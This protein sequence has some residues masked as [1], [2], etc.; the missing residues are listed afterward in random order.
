[1]VGTEKHS[2][3]RRVK[4][5]LPADRQSDHP[6]P[7]PIQES[8]NHAWPSLTSENWLRSEQPGSPEPRRHISDFQ[9]RAI[10]VAQFERPRDLSFRGDLQV[11][12]LLNRPMY[13]RHATRLE[14]ETTGKWYVLLPDFCPTRL[15][16]GVRVAARHAPLSALCDPLVLLVSG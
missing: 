8:D 5:G 6:Y 1:M 2:H 7:S 4:G 15:V 10:G 9:G 3:S 12:N 11:A 13:A 16:S 14:E